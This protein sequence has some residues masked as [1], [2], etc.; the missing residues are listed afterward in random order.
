MIIN[1]LHAD[2]AASEAANEHHRS[3]VLRWVL[4]EAASIAARNARDTPSEQDVQKALRAALLKAEAQEDR[5]ELANRLAAA[6]ISERDV[7]MLAG[8]LDEQE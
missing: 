7:L 6:E 2:L 8:Y 1:R 3:K 5:M 4:G